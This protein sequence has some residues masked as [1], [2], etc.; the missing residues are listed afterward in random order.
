MSIQLSV[1][2]DEISQ[3]F[4]QACQV[5]SG[6]FA[7]GFVELRKLWGKNV[8]ALDGREIA[9]ARR[10]LAKYALRVSSIGSPLFKVDWPDAPRSKHSP[11]R[12]KFSVDYTFAQQPEVLERGLELCRVFGSERL[13]CFDFWR[14]DDVTPYRAAMNAELKKAATLAG[15][16]RVTL[17]ME[18]EFACNTATAAE[19]VR[20]LSGVV[21]P[22]F[23]LNW[24]PGNA[25]FA[26][27]APF[28]DG[29]ALLPKRRI[30]NVH[31]K[32]VAKAADGKPQWTAMGQGTIDFVG[33]FRAL[34][35]DGYRGPITLE[36]HWRGGGTAEESTRQS[37][38]GLKAQLQQAGIV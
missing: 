20:T 28:P 14:L 21:S 30:G 6:E 9:E 31:C 29:Y 8:M 4:E 13:R 32:D 11:A 34:K 22:W 3:D 27:E 38:R 18:N 35:K 25:A 24:D 36:T 19:A 33:Q 17:V 7:L 26:G 10:I 1:F 2:S 23:K 5:A 15:K 16:R 12:D 37:L